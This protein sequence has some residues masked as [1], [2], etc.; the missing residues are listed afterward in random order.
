MGWQLV[1][2]KAFM[3]GVRHR[4]I[5]RIDDHLRREAAERVNERREEFPG[6]VE[7]RQ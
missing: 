6:A 2:H 1:A 5:G 4:A 7:A 3:F